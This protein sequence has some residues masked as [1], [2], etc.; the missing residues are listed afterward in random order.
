MLDASE[1]DLGLHLLGLPTYLEK[2]SQVE[3]HVV[4]VRVAHE[5]KIPEVHGDEIHV[6]SEDE[7]HAESLNH[8]VQKIDRRP[9]SLAS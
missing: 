5:E 2:G 4:H 1:N 3:N 6:G 8:G 7:V 9:R